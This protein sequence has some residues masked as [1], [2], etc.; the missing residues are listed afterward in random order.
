MKAKKEYE[1]WMRGHIVAITAG[2]AAVAAT[3]GSGIAAAVS[4]ARSA[5]ANKD[6]GDAALAT[7][8]ANNITVPGH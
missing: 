3:T 1:R 6:T 5:K 4:L 2:S 8:K 7:A